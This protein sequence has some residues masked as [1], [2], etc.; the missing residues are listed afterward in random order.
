MCKDPSAIYLVCALA[1]MV[2]GT[3]N[4]PN[5]KIITSPLSQTLTDIHLVDMHL[6]ITDYFMG[7]PE[8]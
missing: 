2:I 7:V 4:L 1:I 5:S 6:H 3:E 8:T